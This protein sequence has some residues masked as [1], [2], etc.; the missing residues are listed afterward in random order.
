MLKPSGETTLH[1]S[2]ATTDI[3]GSSSSTGGSFASQFERPRYPIPK[4]KPYR[5]RTKKIT[6]GSL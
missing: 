6:K 1:G 5:N 4:L 2:G 3:R